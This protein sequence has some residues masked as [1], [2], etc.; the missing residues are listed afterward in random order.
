MYPQAFDKAFFFVDATTTYNDITSA[1]ANSEDTAGSYTIAAN[2]DFLYLGALRKFSNAYFERV[3][4][5]TSATLKAEY[6]NGS[7]WTT[8]G[9]AMGFNDATNGVTESGAVSWRQTNLTGWATRSVNSSASLYYVRLSFTAYTGGALK[10]NMIVPNTANRFDI[11]K[12]PND[13][14]AAFSIDGVGRA[15]LGDRVRYSRIEDLNGGFDDNPSLGIIDSNGLARIWAF[16]ASHSAG[17]QFVAGIGSV[18]DNLH[19][20]IHVAS[21]S[22]PYNTEGLSFEHYNGA[23]GRYD[24]LTLNP[25]NLAGVTSAVAETFKS[26]FGAMDG[27]D[28]M[29]GM[30]LNYTNGSHTGTGNEVR[31]LDIGGITPSANASESAIVVGPGWDYAFIASQGNV[32]IGTETPNYRLE[33]GGAASVSQLFGLGLSL[34]N[35][36]HSI[37][38][39]DSATGLFS[40]RDTSTLTDVPL[41]IH[42]EGSAYFNAASLSFMPSGFNVTNISGDAVVALDY[43]NGPASRSIAQTI[44][45]HWT[46]SEGVSVSAN[47]DV[48]GNLTADGYFGAS[49]VTCNGAT[50]KLTWIGGLFGCGVDQNTGGGGATGSIQIREFGAAYNSIPATV[51]FDA[52]KFKLTASGSGDVT[53]S[54]DWNGGGPASLSQNE[55][56]TGAW[57]FANLTASHLIFTSASVSGGLEI[58]GYASASQ[59]FGAGLTNCTGTF[60]FLKW[61]SSTGR[62]SCASEGGGVRS[63]SSGT[64]VIEDNS[65]LNFDSARFSVTSS[66]S[67]ET[68]IALNLSGQWA[69]AGGVSVS[70]NPFE[71]GTNAFYV[72]PTTNRIGINTQNLS[73]ALELVGNASISGNITTFGNIGVGTAGNGYRI[74]STGGIGIGSGTAGSQQLITVVQGLAA[75]EA[76][77]SYQANPFGTA[78]TDGYR[79]GAGSNGGEHG[80]LL[81]LKSAAESQVMARTTS[82]TGNAQ[83]IVSYNPSDSNQTAAVIGMLTNKATTHDIALQYSYGGAAAIDAILFDVNPTANTI[84]SII[85]NNGNQDVPFRVAGQNDANLLYVNGTNGVG[86]GTNAPLTKLEVQGTASA[87]HLLTTGGLQ[88][89]GGAS[90]SYSRFGTVATTHGLSATNDVLINGS[91]EVDGRVFL[92]SSASVSANFEVGGTA[93]VSGALFANGA[94]TIVGQLSFA[95]ASGSGTLELTAGTSKLGINAG[96]FINTMFEVGGTASISGHLDLGDGASSSGNFEIAG[97][98]SVSKV[99]GADLK[100]CD[101]TNQKLFYTASGSNAGKFSCGYDNNVSNVQV[102]SAGAGQTWTR[103][104]SVS[105][106]Y[107]EVWGAGGGGGTSSAGNAS[108]GGGGG[109][110]YSAGLVLVTG[111]VTVNVGTGGTANGGTGGNSSFAGATTPTANGGGGTTTA[112]GGT[113]GTASNGTINLSGQNG[114]GGTGAIDGSKAGDGGASPMGGAG[115]Q[116]FGGQNAGGSARAGTVGQI[117]GG[118]GGGG[119]ENGGAGAAGADGRVIVWAYTGTSRSD[120]AEWYETDGTPDTGD[121]VTMSSA[122]FTYTADTGVHTVAVLTK[123]KAGDAIFGVVST[124]PDIYMGKDILATA[125]HP[126]PI[127][128]AGRVPVSVSTLNGSIKKGD[129]LKVSDLTGVAVRTDKAGQII[130]AAMEDYNGPVGVVGSV[131]TLVQTGFS[132]G[133]RLKKVMAARGI[134]LDSIPENADV[135]QV[136]L[137]QMIQDRQNIQQET[138]I[139]EIFSDRIVA[140]LEIITPRVVTD[141]LTAQTI[142][143][144]GDAFVRGELTADSLHVAQFPQ[145]DNLMAQMAV[146][147]SQSGVLER[148]MIDSRGMLTDADVQFAQSLASQSIRIDSLASRLDAAELNLAALASQSQSQALTFD[149]LVMFSGGLRVDTIGP[150]GDLLTFGGD[151]YFFG[152]PYFNGDTGGFAVIHAGMREVRVPFTTPYLEA[153]VVNVSLLTTASQSVDD[154]LADDVRFAIASISGDGFTIRLAHDAI[155]DTRLSWIAIAVHDARTVFSLL[156]PEPIATPQP[157]VD[158]D[159]QQPTSTPE[160]PVETP[161]PGVSEIP[162]P[163]DTPMTSEEPLPQETP[164]VVESVVPTLDIP[165]AEPIASTPPLE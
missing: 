14:N 156:P 111:N 158:A 28:L 147:A 63:E 145:L 39:Y 129:L 50:Q 44:T 5:P 84:N 157:E 99:F 140:G 112:T 24:A 32:G 34:C 94:L 141:T 66:G 96:G 9:G 26:T 162:I 135:G 131:M 149:N 100:D 91:L 115:G 136:I 64:T 30:F 97:Y 161:I 45:G 2:V 159:D 49:L 52:G 18:S 78:L 139:S 7:S 10:V 142:E 56:V 163:S 54:L 23:P 60:Q 109:G 51:S 92:D 151:T 143:V 132:T 110:A 12:A 121:V 3:A 40:C 29:R 71:V 130:G 82:S 164:I 146:L 122:S 21:K 90:V 20:D 53:V 153:P 86:V 87:S 104:A 67:T 113:G 114:Y 74:R 124:Y 77:M 58:T 137:A 37:L 83:L 17:L 16:S 42:A 1:I 68:N 150:V 73:E 134:D 118:G 62:F 119:E 25:T 57:Q 155:A 81:E 106:V 117:P 127:A 95:N 36:T 126:K 13:T 11:F 93:S 152:R 41:W 33:V 125:R 70:T 55:I 88:V 48:I 69:F 47:L 76:S 165:V 31:A 8:I 22:G 138:D 27:N 107:V 15:A 116:G 123:A 154:L 19:W 61:N 144:A 59:L 105:Q 120:I 103:P 46:F 72:N 148:F 89:A 80:G 35:T 79:F 128:L 160:P 85:I 65:S 98:A 38:Q 6:W 75:R 102:F 108:D 43:T 133:A 101:N 4:G